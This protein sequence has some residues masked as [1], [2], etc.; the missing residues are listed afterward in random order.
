M[1]NTSL[2]L[3]EV[4]ALLLGLSLLGR[5][6]IRAGISPIPLYLVAGLAFG[7]GGALP[8]SASADFVA[9]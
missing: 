8:L 3:I 5:L 9:T 6:A 4:G 2:L 7:R 1:H